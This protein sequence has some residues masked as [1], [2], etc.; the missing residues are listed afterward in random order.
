MYSVQKFAII[1]GLLL[2]AAILFAAPALAGTEGWGT[3]QITSNSYNDYFPRISGPC[4]RM[5]RM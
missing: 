1:Q 4:G 5:A 2:A 3:I